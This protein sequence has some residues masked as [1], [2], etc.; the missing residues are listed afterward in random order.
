MEEINTEND[1][2]TLANELKKQF[3]EKDKEVEELKKN[4]I[5]CYGIIRVIDMQSNGLDDNIVLLR[6]WLSDLVENW[7]D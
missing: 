6:G 7:I 3:E 5:S 2:L 1:Y 4:L